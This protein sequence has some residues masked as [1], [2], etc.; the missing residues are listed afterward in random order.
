MIK[1][2]D[3]PI[4]NEKD[5]RLK[6]K[7]IHTQEEALCLKAELLNHFPE[8]GAHAIAAPQIGLL[9]QAFLARLPS[10][11]QLV[12]FCNPIITSKHDEFEFANEGCL[13]F[14]GVRASTKR[15]QYVTM[16]YLDENFQCQKVATSDLEAVIFQHEIDHLN[17]IL[18]FDHK[19]DL[20]VRKEPKI[21]RNEA[22]PCKSGKK[23][24][25]C[26]LK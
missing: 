17:G 22:C 21:G 10:T 12:L 2:S 13:S 9:A 14:P 3:F 11:E 24:K 18:Y 15:F 4:V 8:N 5:L 20:T 7:Y 1:L 25:K 19:I 23:Y 6:S 16:E 26:C